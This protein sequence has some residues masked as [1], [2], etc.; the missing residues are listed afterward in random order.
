[1]RW[2]SDGTHPSLLSPHPFNDVAT[3]SMPLRGTCQPRCCRETWEL[4]TA[5][6]W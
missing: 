4:L 5:A 1:M 2:W 3:T 6:W